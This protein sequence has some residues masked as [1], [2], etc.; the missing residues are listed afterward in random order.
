[1]WD[2]DGCPCKTFDLDRDD[3]PKNGTF[4][5]E[6]VAENEDRPEHECQLDWFED[7]DLCGGC[8]RDQAEAGGDR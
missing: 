2:G 3:L 4:T 7:V 1:M 8:E 5:A 6:W